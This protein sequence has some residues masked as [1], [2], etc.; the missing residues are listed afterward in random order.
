M[1]AQVG[2]RLLLTLWA[3]SLWSVGY[4]VAPALFVWLD[5]RHLAGLLAG[6]LFEIVAYLGLV[7][8]V[9]LLL[10][11][12]FRHGW[13][14]WRVYALAVM[15]ALTAAGQFALRPLMAAAK[16][17][18]AAA[19]D[20]FAGLHGVSSTLFLIVSL[21]ALALVAFGIAPR[22]SAAGTPA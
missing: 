10:G 14:H 18:G 19:A 21:L 20:R 7:C 2:E 8:G 3:G 15:L 1:F 17:E 9:L 5:D 13:R 11:Q 4:I 6:R 16:A 12:W 22:A